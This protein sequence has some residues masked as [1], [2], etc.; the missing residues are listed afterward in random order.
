MLTAE[1]Q[2]KLFWPSPNPTVSSRCCFPS[3]QQDGFR[4]FSA[5]FAG[6]AF[7]VAKAVIITQVLYPLPLPVAQS[8]RAL[9]KGMGRQFFDLFLLF[10][11]FAASSV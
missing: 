3:A 5:I 9:G 1:C 10:I 11:L 8:P 6:V 4:L 2:C 7:L